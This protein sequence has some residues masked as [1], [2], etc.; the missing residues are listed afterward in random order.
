M[1]QDPRVPLHIEDS[2][3]FFGRMPTASSSTEEDPPKLK[4]TIIDRTDF[5]FDPPPKENPSVWP[6]I[7]ETAKNLSMD[8]WG[9]IGGFTSKRGMVPASHRQYHGMQQGRHM[10]MKH[11]CDL[12]E[13]VS[14]LTPIL[15]KEKR[16]EMWIR[17]IRYMEPPRDEFWYDMV[18]RKH[19][20]RIE[21]NGN[22]CRVYAVALSEA[23][24]HDGS[25]DVQAVN[26]NNREKVAI[27]TLA[28]TVVDCIW[29]V[30]YDNNNRALTLDLRQVDDIE[31]SVAS[32]AR[33]GNVG[34]YRVIPDTSQ[35]SAYLLDRVA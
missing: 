6:R 34:L 25:T 16:A 29:N 11:D 33:D 12:C 5:G 28:E 26:D 19:N 17:L 32:F 3:S 8:Q 22:H 9:V 2:A 4:V 23:V 13:L 20:V 10:A 30:L 1:H 21:K 35:R 24:N 18:L 15:L 7:K 14:M 27:E 31:V